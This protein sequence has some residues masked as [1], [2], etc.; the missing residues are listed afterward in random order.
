MGAC[1]EALDGIL[2]QRQVLSY[3]YAN[4]SKSV[5]ISVIKVQWQTDVTLMIIHYRI[6]HH[7]CAMSYHITLSVT[8]MK[9]RQGQSHN[10]DGKKNLLAHRCY[11]RQGLFY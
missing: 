8:T 5:I 3:L 10:V 11:G 9:C 7:L 1:Y 4:K 6:L 2:E